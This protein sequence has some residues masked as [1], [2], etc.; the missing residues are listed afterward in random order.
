[1]REAAFTGAN[2]FAEREK[3]G[4]MG[5]FQYIVNRL[6]FGRPPCALA[7][8][9]RTT[10]L[11]PLEDRFHARYRQLAFPVFAIALKLWLLRQ[12]LSPS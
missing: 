5:N 3:D 2:D 10:G 11:L 1:V 8:R 4:F 6:L 7:H 12:Y 9:N